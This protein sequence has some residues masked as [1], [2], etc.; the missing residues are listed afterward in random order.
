[1]ELETEF[2]RFLLQKD[3]KLPP[4]L[5]DYYKSLRM[6]RGERAHGCGAV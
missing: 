3:G 1:M 6:T 5:Q 2:D 4:H